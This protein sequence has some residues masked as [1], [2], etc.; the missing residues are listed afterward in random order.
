L[1]IYSGVFF[2]VS[3]VYDVVMCFDVRYNSVFFVSLVHYIHFSVISISDFEGN[4]PDMLSASGSE[5]YERAVM[6]SWAYAWTASGYTGRQEI[7]L[8]E[9]RGPICLARSNQEA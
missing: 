2:N 9:M 4:P 8:L 3:Y 1:S 5:H 7:S 6:L